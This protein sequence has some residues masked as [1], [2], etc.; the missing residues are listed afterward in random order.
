V[1]LEVAEDAPQQAQQ[2]QVAKAITGV[3]VIQPQPVEAV[4]RALAGLTALAAETVVLE[5][6]AP[7]ALSQALQ[8]PMP[9]V[10]EAG[11]MVQ[12]EDR[13]LAEVAQVAPLLAQVPQGPT[14]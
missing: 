5:V 12:E 3:L 7:Q 13:A 8:S 6:T 2:V 11:A 10:E 9:E 4:E 1:V 14:H